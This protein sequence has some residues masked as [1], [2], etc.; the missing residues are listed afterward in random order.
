M[1]KGTGLS[2][3]D[4]D[5]ADYFDDARVHIPLNTIGTQAGIVN[6][7]I[8]SNQPPVLSTSKQ[9]DTATLTPSQTTPTE[10]STSVWGKKSTTSTDGSTTTPTGVA[11]TTVSKIRA[12]AGLRSPA[13]TA[14]IDG[15][16]RVAEPV[17]API[18]ETVE[19]C[20]ILDFLH[21]SSILSSFYSFIYYLL[22]NTSL[23][24]LLSCN[25]SIHL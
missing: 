17:I 18:T 16:V 22:P 4:V 24:F 14:S 11:S 23:F 19:V 20:H 8:P 25:H 12:G 1:S 15:W 21:L 9:A 13:K 2:R 5:E 10:T 3:A 6:T 7:S